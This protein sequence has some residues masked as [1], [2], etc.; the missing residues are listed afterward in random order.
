MSK[1]HNAEISLEQCRSTLASLGQHSASRSLKG[2]EFH[3]VA[4]ARLSLAVIQNTVVY[5]VTAKLLKEQVV[6]TL[7]AA[8]QS[9]DPHGLN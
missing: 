9:P 6:E 4:T 8:I 3:S 1:L 2:L 7:M 5:G